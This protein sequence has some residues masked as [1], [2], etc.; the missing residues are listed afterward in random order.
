MLAD[1]GEASY[2]LLFAIPDTS[3]V[4]QS[5]G[6]KLTS[7]MMVAICNLH[8]EYDHCTIKQLY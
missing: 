4:V 5:G 8:V 6:R 1:L 3:Q 2:S 7:I